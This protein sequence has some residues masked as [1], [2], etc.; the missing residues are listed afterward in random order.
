MKRA[1]VSTNQ[2]GAADGY[3]VLE[4]EVPLNNMF[5]YTADL[6]RVTAGKGEFIMEFAR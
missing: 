5:G 2:D 3:F 1:A 6:R 4:C